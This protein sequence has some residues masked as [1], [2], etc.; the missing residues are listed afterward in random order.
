M[1][2]EQRQEQ[3]QEKSA[4]AE[5]CEDESTCESEDGV[6]ASDAADHLSDVPDGSGC[7]E[8]WEHLSEERE[9]DD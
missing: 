1:T 8:I 2:T 6:E 3:R 7:A 4:S 9:N 5:A